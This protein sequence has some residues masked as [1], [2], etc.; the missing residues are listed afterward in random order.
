MGSLLGIKKPKV[1]ENAYQ[2]PYAP[3]LRSRLLAIVDSYIK[4]KGIDAFIPEENRPYEYQ[5]DDERAQIRDRKDTLQYGEHTDPNNDP[6]FYY[7][8][9]PRTPKDENAI[10]PVETVR[11][12]PEEAPVADSP[13]ATINQGQGQQLV[14]RYAK[15]ALAAKLEAQRMGADPEALALAAPK[16]L[17]AA[18]QAQQQQQLDDVVNFIREGRKYRRGY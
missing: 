7:P 17:S 2:D 9:A 4:K 15:A 8:T 13:S 6:R 12:E 1:D 10:K 11:P 5:S 3:E 14:S 16:E 18:N